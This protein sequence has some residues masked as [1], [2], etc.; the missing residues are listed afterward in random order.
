MSRYADLRKALLVIA[1]YSH[2]RW[3]HQGGPPIFGGMTVL[4]PESWA[5][6]LPTDDVRIEI[7]PRRMTHGLFLLPPTDKGVH[8]ILAANWEFCDGSHADQHAERAVAGTGGS[9]RGAFR[10]FIF[11]RSG[12][13]SVAPTVVRFDE[14]EEGESWCFAHAQLCDMMTPYK[15]RFLEHDRSQWISSTLP[16][17]PL[18]ATRGAGPVLVCVLAGLYGIDD[19]LLRRVLRE[20]P[21]KASRNVASRLKARKSRRDGQL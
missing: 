14:G 8:C 4:D 10:V 11:P 6:V 3:Q 5:K 1:S 20:L 21:D 18:A 12:G 7:P 2:R 15:G 13:V 16:R 9:G 19:P 17:I